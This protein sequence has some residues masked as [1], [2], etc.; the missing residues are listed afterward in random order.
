MWVIF[1]SIALCALFFCLFLYVGYFL[2]IA[3]CALFYVVCFMLFVLCGLVFIV[4][5][6]FYFSIFRVDFY[7][8]AVR[9][10]ALRHYFFPAPL[11]HFPIFR[12]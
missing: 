12:L 7:N 5:F 3:L 2:S 6:W 9:R 11:G 1:L 4:G 10:L 8:F